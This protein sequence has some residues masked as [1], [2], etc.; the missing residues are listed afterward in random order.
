[1]INVQFEFKGD[2]YSGI[3]QETRKR[4]GRCAAAM[5]DEQ[6]E[7]GITYDFGFLDWT[8]EHDPS[9]VAEWKIQLENIPG[10]FGDE[11]VNL[12][13]FLDLKNG[14]EP[15]EVE[16]S[17][18]TNDN[19]WRLLFPSEALDYYD[20]DPSGLEEKLTEKLRMQIK[21]IRTIIGDT[22]KTIP[23]VDKLEF[24]PD[25]DPE[26]I[27]V[28]LEMCELKLSNNPTAATRQTRFKVVVSDS[29][30]EGPGSFFLK[31]ATPEPLADLIAVKVE[32][33]PE[34]WEIPVPL[35]QPPH[36]PQWLV[37]GLQ[38][39]LEENI[40]RSRVRVL[41]QDYHPVLGR[42]CEAKVTNDGVVLSPGGDSSPA[43]SCSQTP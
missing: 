1:V 16:R 9:P 35:P 21:S 43:F 11:T 3:E 13:H 20:Q 31:H 2:L 30:L 29:E 4:I 39:Y 19:A 32:A 40:S 17:L 25:Q 34:T 18:D 10:N 15:L 7:R 36:S 5:F 14:E 12:R 22:L 38:A 8:S 27:V 42:S 28:P 24:K 6:E 33:V 37:E 41:V 26:R 23:V